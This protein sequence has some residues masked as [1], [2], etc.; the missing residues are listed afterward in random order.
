MILT[1]RKEMGVFVSVV[2]ATHFVACLQTLWAAWFVKQSGRVNLVQTLPHKYESNTVHSCCMFRRHR[3]YWPLLS[4]NMII[5]IF[6]LRCLIGP[7]YLCLCQTWTSCNRHSL[8]SCSGRPLLKQLS[9][10]WRKRLDIHLPASIRNQPSRRSHLRC[11]H[12]R[13]CR[14]QLTV[15]HTL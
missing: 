13:C 11:S 7:S 15:F 9:E 12:R 14:A 3:V 2:P 5:C 1:K 4:V 6:I 8:C 10:Q